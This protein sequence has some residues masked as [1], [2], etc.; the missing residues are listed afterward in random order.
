ML[1]VAVGVLWTLALAGILAHVVGGDWIIPA[2]AVA[3][4]LPIVVV[5]YL[6]RRV[7]ADP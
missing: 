5:R 6:R 3:L 4:A 7:E 1:R 2:A